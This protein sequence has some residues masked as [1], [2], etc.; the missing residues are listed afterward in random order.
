MLTASCANSRTRGSVGLLCCRWMQRLRSMLRRR[1]GSRT[2]F[3]HFHAF[4][5]VASLVSNS[6][7]CSSEVARKRRATSARDHWILADG[8]AS[9]TF[10][11]IASSVV[12]G[13]WLIHKTP[14]G[15]P[16]TN[17]LGICKECVLP[18]NLLGPFLS[19]RYSCASC[20]LAWCSHLL[21]CFLAMLS[22]WFLLL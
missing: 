16:N 20:L 4:R 10:F 7:V 9:R 21:V 12:V 2:A 11:S 19:R 5:A 6:W 8:A 14:I 17:S 22:S 3:L 15:M 1:C 13:S 18:Q